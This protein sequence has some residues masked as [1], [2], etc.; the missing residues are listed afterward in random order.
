MGTV[1]WTPGQMH[2]WALNKQKALK[3]LTDLL[4]AC[5][6]VGH[7]DHGE[8]PIPVSVGVYGHLSSNT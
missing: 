5:V 1:I 6:R 3:E 4:G 8:V 2:S 7:G